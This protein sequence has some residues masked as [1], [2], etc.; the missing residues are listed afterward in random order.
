MAAVVLSKALN[1]LFK[2]GMFRGYG[3]PKWSSN[4]NHLS[5]VDDTIVFAF[6]ERNS[7]QR[8]MEVFHDCENV[9]GQKI[10]ADKSSFYMHRKVATEINQEVQQVIGFS[11]GDFSFTYLGRPICHARRQKLFYKD[12]TKKTRDKLKAWKGK[13]LS[14]GGKAVLISCGIQSIPIY[15]L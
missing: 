15:L 7:L 11:R 12:V 10:N 3:M 13:W 1:Y 2:D 5:Y 9:S 6:A 4:L 14:F 8:I